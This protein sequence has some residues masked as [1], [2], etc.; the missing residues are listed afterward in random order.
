M[1]KI[2]KIASL[3]SIVAAIGL[4]S[5]CACS[6]KQDKADERAEKLNEKELFF[7]DKDARRDFTTTYKKTYTAVDTITTEYVVVKHDA[8]SKK[9]YLSYNKK[10]KEGD[11]EEKEIS[12]ASHTIMLEDNKVVVVN[13]KTQKRVITEFEDTYYALVY[14]SQLVNDGTLTYDYSSASI[15]MYDTYK[16]VPMNGCTSGTEEENTA[17]AKKLPGILAHDTDSKTCDVEKKLFGKDYTYTVGYVISIAQNT[18][19]TIVVDGNA[20]LTSLKREDTIAVGTEKRVDKEIFTQ[21]LKIK[22]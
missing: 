5:G 10:V 18:N 4:T 8:S 20:E 17:K 13:N 19:I 15:K 6:V 7:S 22:N 21:I 16:T 9:I 2:M 11:K 1:K 14:S 12:N 3:A